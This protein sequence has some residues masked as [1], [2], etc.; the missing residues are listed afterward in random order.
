MWKKRSTRGVAYHQHLYTRLIAGRESDEI[1]RWLDKEFET[2]AAEALDKATSDSRLTPEDWRLLVRFLAAQDVRTPA[3]LADFLQ[4]WSRDAQ[5]FMDE[6][7]KNSVAKAEAAYE[8]GE[9]LP[10]PDQPTHSDGFPVRLT[11]KIKPGEE[12][13]EL[14][15]EMVVGRSFW[16]W[17]IKHL[18]F[19]TAKALH[20][21]R[22]TILAPPKDLTWFTSDNPVVRLNFN[23]PSEYDFKGSWDSKGTDIFFPISPNHLLYTQVGYRPPSRG[24][25]MPPIQAN[26]V[27]RFIAEHAD[28]MIFAAEP[29]DQ[30][31]LLRPRDV[32]DEQ[33]K[34]E[35]KQ[36]VEWHEDQLK[37]ERNLAGKKSEPDGGEE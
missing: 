37:A 23:G 18:L 5:S 15:A 31:A 22:W 34:F 21:H 7:I 17:S 19:N 20:E 8:A 1:E 11:K 27:R 35:R 28:R 24:E 26:M 33:V 25:A 14:R 12:Y 29:D 6:T 4:Q 32:S 13:G 16:L 2:P 9:E 3:R 36:W 30:V 10:I